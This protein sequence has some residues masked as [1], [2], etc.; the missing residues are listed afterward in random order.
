VREHASHEWSAMMGIAVSDHPP[1][2][3]EYID[4]RARMGWGAIEEETAIKTIQA[5]SFTACLRDNGRLIGLARVMGDGV[6][7]F[8]LADLIVH[9]KYRGGGHGDGLMR[10]VTDY[11]DR[12][13]KP[14]ASITLVALN[15][16]ETFYERF[17]FVRCPNGPFGMGMHYPSAPAPRPCHA[18]R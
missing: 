10:L 14:G 2:A 18:V 1:S 17:G 16:R 3:A 9:P 4:L 6:L 12:N 11:F 13:A 7:Y 5:A 8:F 15:G